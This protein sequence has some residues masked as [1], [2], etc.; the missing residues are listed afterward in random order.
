VKKKRKEKKK[1][2][3]FCICTKVSGCLLSETR[4]AVI[5]GL[6]TLY[7]NMNMNVSLWYGRKSSICSI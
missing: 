1:Q 6:P 2:Q 5:V 4:A 3:K 7:M